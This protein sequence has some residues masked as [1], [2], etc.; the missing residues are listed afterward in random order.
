MSVTRALHA[1]LFHTVP[2]VTLLVE[3]Y[4]VS[5]IHGLWCLLIIATSDQ[6]QLRLIANLDNLVVVRQNYF[7]IID[8][9][10]QFHSTDAI[11]ISVVLKYVLCILF[12]DVDEL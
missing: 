11:G 3:H 12:D 4:L 7:Q 10:I 8:P 9:I 2:K 5:I 1:R 6:V